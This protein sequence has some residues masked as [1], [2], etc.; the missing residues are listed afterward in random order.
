MRLGLLIF[1]L[2]IL[3]WWAW[4]VSGAIRVNGT[5]RQIRKRNEFDRTQ[6]EQARIESI[7]F[8][9]A[10]KEGDRIGNERS[11]NRKVPEESETGSSE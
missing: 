4:L 8:Q 1:T 11:I 2:P 9:N 10:W 5:P 7:R 3:L 6:F